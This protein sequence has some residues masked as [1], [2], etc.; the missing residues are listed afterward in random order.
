MNH[1]TSKLFNEKM[2][3]LDNE[4][5]KLCSAEKTSFAYMQY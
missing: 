5:N 4:C 3:Q 1:A 2:G